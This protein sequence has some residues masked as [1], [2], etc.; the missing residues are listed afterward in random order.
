MIVEQVIFTI[1]AFAL[2]V[3]MFLKMI[4][5]NDTTYV[6]ILVLEAIGIAI[7][8]I[9]ILFHI[10]LHIVFKILSYIL[11]IIL[12]IV[13]F[14]IE[15]QNINLME[16]LNIVKAKIY[17]I[18]KNN[19]YAKKKLIELVTKYPESY[20][21]HKMLAEIYEKEGGMRKAIDEYVQAI[22]IN[23]KDYDS[24]YKVADLLNQSDKKEEASQM[25]T[26]L[27]KKRPDYT[28]ASELLGD[29]LLSQENYKEAVTVYTE[30]LNY[31]LTNYE[32]NYSLGIA[33]TM[34]NDFQNASVYYQ[35]AAEINSLEY[36]TKYSLAEIALIYK[37]LEEAEKYFMQVL[38]D[39]ELEADAYYELAKISIIKG[40]KEQAINYAN[41]AI[42]SNALKIVDKIKNDSIFIPILAKLS[43]PFNIPEVKEK[44]SKLREKETKAK[45]HLENMSEITRTLSYNDI[46]LLKKNQKHNDGKIVD[47]SNEKEQKE[48]E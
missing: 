14:I 37:E 45:E 32:L 23:K 46:R 35:K 10:Q 19:R 34:L 48:R 12:P 13:V 25:L 7:E 9:E 26:N 43:I 36:N 42:E 24:Y 8:F 44:N 39:E 17:F 1:I 31:S 22:D 11:S 6:P 16:V 3:L 47:S 38:E 5:K 29:I 28:K 18:F 41:I 33:Y 20:Y 2:F 27:L 40:S 30:A 21:G 4:Q 15:K